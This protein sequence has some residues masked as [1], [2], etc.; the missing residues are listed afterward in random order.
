MR[1][2][3]SKESKWLRDVGDFHFAIGQL[4]PACPSFVS[5]E[6]VDLR[7]ELIKEEYE[8]W[9]EA[10]E[11]RDLTETAD[12]LIDMI[13]VVLGTL[14]A[15]GLPAEALW[16]EVHRTNMSK[17]AGPKRADGKQLKPEGWRPPDLHSIIEYFS[18]EL[19]DG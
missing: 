7:K 3:R 17:A 8:E 15:F 9:L 11:A 5:D 13:V 10:V 2:P 6:V 16:D 18:G 19:T 14:R 12:A 1:E 4:E